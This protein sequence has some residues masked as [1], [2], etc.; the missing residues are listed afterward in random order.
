LKCRPP[1]N[2]DPEAEEVVSCLP[3]LFAQIHLLQPKI[4]CLLGKVAL[5][6]FFGPKMRLKDVRG[7]AFSRWGLQFFCTYHPAAVLHNPQ[8]KQE[9]QRDFF[10]L[11][12]LLR[13]LAPEVVV[14]S[15][16]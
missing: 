15:G 11:C 5:E 10:A 16:K 14:A 8:L 6:G 1:D 13:T 3:Y 4:I 9:L 12:Q 7:K 2:R